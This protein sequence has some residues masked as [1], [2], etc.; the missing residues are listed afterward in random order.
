MTVV[1]S[2][3][4]NDSG[5]VYYFDPGKLELNQ[6]EMVVVETMHGPEL[7][8]VIYGEF[9]ISEEEVVGELKPVIRRAEDADFQRSRSL[10]QRHPRVMTICNT[11]IHEHGL[12]MRLIKA[13]Y[14]FDGSRLTFY[15]TS[16]HRV[17]FRML[18]RDLAYTFKTRIELRQVGPRDKARLLGGI[19]MCGRELCCKTFLSNYARVSVKMAKEQDLPLNPSKISGV[20]GRLLCCLSYEHEQYQELRQGLP[21]RG[22][23]VK[24][25]DGTGNVIDVNVLGQTVTVQLTVSGMQES[26]PL[27]NI[28]EMSDNEQPPE[29]MQ[30]PHRHATDND[31]PPEQ[32]PRLS[33]SEILDLLNGE[34]FD[35]ED[36]PPDTRKKTR[37][38]AASASNPARKPERAPRESAGTPRRPK[39]RAQSSTSEHPTPAS[40]QEQKN[41][42]GRRRK[43]KPAKD[44]SRQASSTNHT[45]TNQTPSPP[46]KNKS[47]S[48]TAS[49]S[50]TPSRSRPRRKKGRKQ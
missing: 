10:Q 42:P 48:E 4:F 5:R 17:D 23:R 49:T 16:E 25:P 2:V 35:L 43:R 14:N 12:S 40:Q 45:P 18:V 3:R 39:K 33:Y 6:G 46:G 21:R 7:G 44:P 34:L 27:A 13:E 47:S 38:R 1:V 28:R 19:G 11:K 32:S 41:T 26:Y 22:A 8:K 30:Q 24:T 9:E 31:E 29:Q 37:A 15:F 36:T 20:C 50:E